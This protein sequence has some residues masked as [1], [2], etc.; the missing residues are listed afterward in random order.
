MGQNAK[1][2]TI[3]NPDEAISRTI[4]ENLVDGCLPCAVAF[5][6]AE[7]LGLSPLTIGGYADAL[8]I[9]LAKC[10]MGLYG[11]NGGKK[12]AVPDGEPPAVLANAIR[13]ALENDRLTC[14][15]A[16]E[17]AARK[18]VS[19]MAVAG[20]CEKMGIRI[21]VCQLGAF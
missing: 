7:S 18:G 1:K 9:K 8:S 5:K 16:W 15:R 2:M 10:Q 20:A 13:S 19:K 12:I 4:R 6:L 21:H 3:E 17:I 14:E 11:Y